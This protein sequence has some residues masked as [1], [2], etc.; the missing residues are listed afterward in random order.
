MKDDPLEQN[1]LA[2][3][4]KYFEKIEELKVKLKQLQKEYSDPI[5]DE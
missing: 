1:D 2:T 5:L 4:A 3:D